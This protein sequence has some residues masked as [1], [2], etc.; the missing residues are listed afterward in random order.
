MMI[1]SNIYRIKRFTT[2]EFW[3]TEQKHPNI[4]LQS[5]DIKIT[6]VTTKACKP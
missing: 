4:V 3:S 6:K 2:D 1:L 5:P